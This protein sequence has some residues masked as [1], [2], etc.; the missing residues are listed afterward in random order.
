[1]SEARI[2][3]N[4]ENARKST[5]PRSAEGKARSSRNATT[6]GLTAAK[7]A[8]VT[9]TRLASAGEALTDAFPH[10]DPSDAQIIAREMILSAMIRERRR[11]VVRDGM[12]AQGKPT[13]S[14]QDLGGQMTVPK[15]LLE[16]PRLADY[17]RKS[18][19]RL[20]SALKAA[21]R[22]ATAGENVQ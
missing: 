5:G 12:S 16:L 14:K 15:S 11:E 1:M 9:S 19:S 18:A 21:A 7:P 13:P 8:G 20:R 22:R 3:A 17:E 4:R 6:H 10:L 2:R